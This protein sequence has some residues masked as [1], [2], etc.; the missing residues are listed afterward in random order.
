MFFVRLAPV[1]GLLFKVD[2]EVIR[3]DRSSALSECRDHS[4]GNDRVSQ[5]GGAALARNRLKVGRLCANWACSGAGGERI[6]GVCD[7]LTHILLC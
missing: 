3:E 1:A 2:L 4:T 5:K 6:A 7:I